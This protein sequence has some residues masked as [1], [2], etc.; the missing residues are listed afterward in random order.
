MLYRWLE[1]VFNL[2]SMQALYLL[3]RYFRDWIVYSRASKIPV[4][5]VDSYPCLEDATAKTQFDAHYFFQ[6]AWMSRKL[7]RLPPRKHVDIGSDVNVIGVISA[8][9][10]TM[11][12]D[13]RP[14]DVSL[15]GL[16]NRRG[17]LLHLEFSDGSIDSLSCLHVIEH[18]GL[19]RYGDLIDPEGTL[20]AA[21]ELCRVLAPQGSLFLSVPVGRERVCF[22]AHRV[23]SPDSV[24][25]MFAML[26]LQDCALVNDEG[27][28][29]ENVAPEM[30]IGCTYGCGMFH[31]V[32]PG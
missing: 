18:I 11:F 17:D 15:N 7:S 23:F 14:L 5:F 24:L 31:F 32:K 10:D 16:E 28:Y 25:R 30:M 27:K 13:Y 8:F 20:K 22:N 29:Q 9:V 26:R 21:T 12:V 4:K 2:R 3:P 1:T 19:G 6:S